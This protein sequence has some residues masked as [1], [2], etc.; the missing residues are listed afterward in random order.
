MQ[1]CPQ[2]RLVRETAAAIPRRTGA[3]AFTLIELLVVITII[4]ILA[5]IGIPAFKGFGKSNAMSAAN[6][7]LL[8]DIAGARSRA[9]AGHTT[10][11]MVF[12]PPQIVTPNMNLVLSGTAGSQLTNLY[13]GQYTTYALLS[14]RSVGEQPGRA[15]PRYLTAWRALPTG[16]FIA[17]N[18]FGRYQLN[19]TDASRA[20]A[21]N[22]FPFPL[23][24][25]GTAA[26]LPF[27]GFDYLGRLISQ[28][29]EYIPLARGSIFYARDASTGKFSKQPADIQESPLGNSINNSN[30][31]HID[32][33]T[34]RARVE[35]Q[36]IQ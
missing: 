18:K 8:D 23:A 34:G 4:A 10:V 30:V 28:R 17:T 29:D 2:N 9:I 35:R 31:V 16:V 20:F 32:W 33:L 26:L 36:E 25:N 12:V 6:R 14:L 22:V 7:Q 11:Y 1:T 24:T 13:G 15:N 5:S 3:T 19:V 21:T 27:I